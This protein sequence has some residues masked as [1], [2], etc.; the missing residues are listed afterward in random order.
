M[1]RRVAFALVVLLGL[2]ALPLRCPAPLVYRA[3]EGWTY[4]SVGEGK[5]TRARAK[6]Q[7]EVA[8][9]AFNKKK[10]R[11]ALK[12][13][14]RT[15]KRWP[16]SDYAPKAQYLVGRCYEARKWDEKAFKEYQLVVQKYP[17]ADSYNEILEREYA[18]ASRF[19]RGQWFKLWGVIPFFPSME[20]TA[21]MFTQIVRDG[22]FSE[23]GPD[24]QMA[25]GA[26]REKQKFY[27][28]AV[29][30]YEKAADMY[31]ENPKLTANATF[32]AGLAWE[33]QA[34]TA[35][36]DQSAAAQAIGTFNDFITLYPADR[37]VPQ[38]QSTISAL[39]TEQSSGAFRI[40]Q[41]YEKQFRWRAA[42]IYY[43]ATV[44]LDRESTYAATALQRLEVLRR[45]MSK[46]IAG[47]ATPAPTTTAP[48]LP[49]SGQGEPK[50]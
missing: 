12:A 30:V 33:M 7:F 24:A 29:R 19:L 31:G 17:K 34:K 6:D 44:A 41:Y 3:G 38:A 21:E 22:P 36:Y 11:L 20:K 8:Q 37:R 46:R 49:M 45:R 40:A 43:N 2:L 1:M 35:E 26:T 27:E 5:W 32:K 16:L 42:E 25:L 23:V 28:L 48:S 47:P 13:A 50:P 14:R 18:I 15:V 10:Y 9:D 39:R 4:E